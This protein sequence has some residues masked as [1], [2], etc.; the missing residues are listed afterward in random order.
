[1]GVALLIEEIL[2][3]NTSLILH[4]AFITQFHAQKIMMLIMS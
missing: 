3:K 2:G 1:M 4:I